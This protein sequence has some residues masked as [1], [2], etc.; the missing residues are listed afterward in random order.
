[1]RSERKWIMT[2]KGEYGEKERNGILERDKKQREGL[3][4]FLGRKSI[5]EKDGQHSQEDGNGE[6]EEHGEGESLVRREEHWE[7]ARLGRG[8]GALCV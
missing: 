1:M 7:V 4:A 5:L 8:V 2:K 3:R 6:R